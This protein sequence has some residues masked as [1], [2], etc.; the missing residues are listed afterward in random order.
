MATP[1]Q[2]LTQFHLAQQNDTQHQLDRAKVL[3]AHVSEVGQPMDLSK[4]QHEEHAN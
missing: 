4:F 2:E 1:F 3:A